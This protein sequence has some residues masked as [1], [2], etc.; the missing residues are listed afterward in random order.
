[1][2]TAIVA[3][4]AL[5]LA[6]SVALPAVAQT[7]SSDARQQAGVAF[8]VAASNY[9]DIV[10]LFLNNR[11]GAMQAAL[12]SVREVLMRLRRR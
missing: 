8:A 7:P 11:T 3:V 9:E 6:V 1:M 4:F 12:G 2:P 5:V 10:N